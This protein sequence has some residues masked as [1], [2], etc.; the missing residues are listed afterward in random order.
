MNFALGSDG[1]AQ[2]GRDHL[3]RY[4]GFEP[5]YAQLNVDD[6][7][8]SPEDARETVRGYRDLGFDRLL[9]HPTVSSVDQLDR[10]ADAVL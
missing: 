4:Y 3:A 7:I 10:L 8:V 2:A 1:T 9:F 6:L 5:D